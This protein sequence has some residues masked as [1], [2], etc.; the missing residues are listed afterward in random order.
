MLTGSE[1]A[2]ANRQQ[3]IANDTFQA[4]GNEAKNAD[5]TAECSVIVVGSGAVSQQ[6]Q[7]CV[8]MYTLTADS[9]GVGSTADWWQW[10]WWWW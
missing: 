10:K 7:P 6:S 9:V 8:Q 4:R 2:E 1:S 3:R 5:G